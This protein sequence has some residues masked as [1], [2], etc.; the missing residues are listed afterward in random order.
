M[1][2]T[3]T[4][5]LVCRVRVGKDSY[6]YLVLKIVSI[7]RDD[8]IGRRLYSLEDNRG[9]AFISLVISVYIRGLKSR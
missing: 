2:T 9:T 5:T 6:L 4:T 1:L 8:S 7:D 3:P